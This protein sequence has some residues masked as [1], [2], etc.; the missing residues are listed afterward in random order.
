MEQT[1]ITVKIYD[2]L[3]TAF[4]RDIDTLF[5]KRDAFLNQM[6]RIETEYL[7]MDMEGKRLSVRA[8][9]HIAG[10]LKQLGTTTVNIVVDQ[11]V[12]D[13]LK[14]VVDE[15]NIVRDSFINRMLWLLRGGD[16]L[17]KYLDLPT[18]ITGSEFERFI[19]A[20]MPTAPLKAMGAVQSDPL[21]YLRIA[22][23]ERHNTG[24]Y[25]LDLPN[26]FTGMACWIDDRY[27]P[28]TSSYI[29]PNILLEELSALESDAFSN[30]TPPNA[31]ENG[32]QS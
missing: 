8:K 19:P 18:Y 13:A 15:S 29:D 26:K 12:S 10:S 25:L 14:A 20:A 30:F 5:L 22:C 6:I 9:R 3:L 1:K 16:A 4:N 24:L 11:T 7:A 2:K 27:V 31:S 17:L 23:E 32:D 21:H 28:G